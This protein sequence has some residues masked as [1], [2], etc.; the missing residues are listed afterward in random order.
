MNFL[1]GCLAM[2]L[3][4]GLSGTAR[5][6]APVAEVVATQ[7]LAADSLRAHTFSLLARGQVTEA[8][9]YWVLTTGKDAPAWLLAMRTSFEAGKQVAGACQSVAQNIHTAFTQLGGKP[10]LVQLTT[11][12]REKVPYIT[13][14]LMN[15]QDV[16]LS[17]NGYHVLVRMQGRAYDAYTGAAGMPWAEYMRRLGARSEIAEEV[18]ETVVGVP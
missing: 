7:V 2:F 18:I 17:R 11:Q 5:A 4:V 6:A 12:P 14:K 16:N 8:I 1:R 3:L 9:D 13:F 15:G 10:E